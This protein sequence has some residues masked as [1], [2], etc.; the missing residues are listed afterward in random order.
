MGVERRDLLVERLIGNPNGAVVVTSVSQV[1]KVQARGYSSDHVLGASYVST[2]NRIGS[3]EGEYSQY[4][5]H[6]LMKRV[7]RLSQNFPM[8]LLTR[9]PVFGMAPAE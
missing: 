5:I 9:G 6:A 1:Y 3:R 8:T 7:S 4:A 2:F